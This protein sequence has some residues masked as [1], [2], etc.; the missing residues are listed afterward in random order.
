LARATIP[1]V[2]GI[3]RANINDC[4]TVD[5]S[6][7]CAGWG[8]AGI[9]DYNGDCRPD[10]I[11]SAPF[12][13][14]YDYRWN[15]KVYLFL[16]D[17]PLYKLNGTIQHQVV[18]KPVRQ[19]EM[20]LTPANI[21]P[22][23]TNR[24]GFYEVLLKPGVFYTVKPVKQADFS[25][26]AISAYDAALVA[27]HA[28]NLEPLTALQQQAADVNQDRTVNLLDAA[29]IL[30]DAVRLSPLP[31][32][33][34]RHW[35]FE[36]ASRSYHSVTRDIANENYQGLIL[37]D[38]DF[39]W[40]PDSGACC[41]KW[42]NQQLI[43]PDSIFV[44]ANQPMLLPVNL[45]PSVA[46]LSLEIELAY[47]EQ[48][49]RFS[50]CQLTDV[51]HNWTRQVHAEPGQLQAAFYGIEAIQTNEPVL[52]LIFQTQKPPGAPSAIHISRLRFNNLP[53]LTAQ[54]EVLTETSPLPARGYQLSQ[55]YPNPFN[56]TTLIQFHLP[57]T[58]VVQI[59]IYNL[60]GKTVNQ[61]VNQK[62]P[63]GTHLIKWSGDNRQRHPLPA[64]IYYYAITAG[65]FKQIRKL[66][67]LP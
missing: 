27:R 9:G 22:G 35:R 29:L 19:V 13:S 16:G 51:T 39:S 34:V 57:Q 28:L 12:T 49:L 4:F 1:I 24:T 10:F 6:I 64:G 61:L 66:V 25:T 47:D 38:V 15:G 11:V 45:P 8:S 59:Q 50:E 30:Q 32:S 65:E 14:C 46:V 60:L 44:T 17:H 21:R 33:K 2:S 52:K 26:N 63:A 37:G 7:C 62:F 3:I 40:D 67:L 43:L 23:F 5:D 18:E 36:P 48:T 20:I 42:V 54:I 53:T 55:N 58:E 56:R 41:Q 31:I